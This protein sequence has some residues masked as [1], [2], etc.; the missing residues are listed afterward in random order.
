M[1][2][3][4]NTKVSRI[5]VRQLEFKRLITI[6]SIFLFLSG[7][8]RAEIRYV[9]PSGSN[10]PPYLSWQNAARKIQ[11]CI[12]I[13]DT[14]DTV[15]VANGT[16][17]DT[18]TIT[19]K[20]YVIGTSWDSTIIDGTGLRKQ[21]VQI[22]GDRFGGSFENFTVIGQSYSQ[23]AIPIISY[24]D[25]LIKNCKILN[26][27]TGVAVLAGSIVFES[28]IIRSM[29]FEGYYSGCDNCLSTIKNNIILLKNTTGV[30]G[31]YID[32]GGHYIIR[33]NIFYYSPVIPNYSQHGIFLAWPRRVHI[34]NNFFS[35]FNDNIKTD[36]IEDTL[37]IYN[38]FFSGERSI[39]IQTQLPRIKIRN[40]IFYNLNY[41]IRAISRAIPN[42]YNLFYNNKYNAH[43]N[44]IWGDSCIFNRDPMF[45]NDVIDTSL[46]FDLHLQKYSPAIDKGDPSIL[47]PGQ[48]RSDIG[49]YGGPY[50]EEYTYQNYAPASPKNFTVSYDTLNILLKWNKNSESDT[51]YY[52]LY[53]DTTANFIIDSTKRIAKLNINQY[54]YVQ[55]HKYR[56]YYFKLTATDSQGNESVP[57]EEK[58]VFITGIEE[59][60]PVQITDYRLYQNYPNPFNPVTRIPY[61]L[62]ERGLVKLTLYSITGEIVRTIVYKEQAAGYYEEE[63]KAKGLSS[64]M[65]LYRIEV[66]NGNNT[67]VF[68]EMKK[69]ILIK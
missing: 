40:N 68:T 54:T 64:G 13:C 59:N 31:M 21:T 62:K 66:L 43:G 6:V 1:G 45:V 9:S 24:K 27:H 29:S 10:T 33:N 15:F 19:K 20:I 36:L 32:I 61:R 58:H 51:V 48:S 53:L 47:D 7:S 11:D 69:T 16:Y 63:L 49:L 18:V 17:R 52:S 2:I 12:N 5:F 34:Q 14:D 56:N 60:Y 46:A 35:G 30:G 25:V 3:R 23:G 38:N 28:N 37:F 42:D 57:S 26:A 44:I 50:G 55:P 65:Y 4:V 67:P 39:A 41:G 8:T 22:I